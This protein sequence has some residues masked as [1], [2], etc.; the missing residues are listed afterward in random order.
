MSKYPVDHPNCV[1][2]VLPNDLF[3]IH[4]VVRRVDVARNEEPPTLREYDYYSYSS[5]RPKSTTI[6]FTIDHKED[7]DSKGHYMYLRD[8]R[9]K[10]KLHKT[11][12][13]R[14]P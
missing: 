4:A 13:L 14:K 1:V 3:A 12:G 6:T 11:I 10:P 5:P 9:E 7:A 8:Q 2:E